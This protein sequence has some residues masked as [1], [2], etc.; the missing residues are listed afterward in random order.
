M[1]MAIKDLQLGDTIRISPFGTWNTAIV[2][3]VTEKEVTIFR[4]YGTTAS[5]SYT[6]G[7]I[8]YLGIEEYRVLRDSSIQYEVLERQELR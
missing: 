2:K 4:P 7:V 1:K 5:F 6:G 3:Q 8:C